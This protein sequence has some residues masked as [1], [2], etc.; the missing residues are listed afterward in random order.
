ML[1]EQYPIAWMH[2]PLV[3]GANGVW[4]QLLDTF[5]YSPPVST[6]STVQY[7]VSLHMCRVLA[8]SLQWHYRRTTSPL[9][10]RLVTV[11]EIHTVL[12]HLYLSHPTSHSPTPG[13]PAAGAGDGSVQALAAQYNHQIR[14]HVCQCLGAFPPTLWVSEPPESSLGYRLP[15]DTVSTSLLFMILLSCCYDTVGTVREASYE[16]LGRCAEGGMGCGCS[17]SH[18]GDLVTAVL[19]KYPAHGELI[20]CKRQLELICI[21]TT[22]P[23]P[24][25]PEGGKRWDGLIPL[26]AVLRQ[27]IRSHW[28]SL[29][30]AVYT[31]L[32]TC[33][34]GVTDTKVLARVHAY[35]TLGTVLQVRTAYITHNIAVCITYMCYCRCTSTL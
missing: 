4:R 32:Y 17:P 16:A 18:L 5:V 22:S 29:L 19:T 35:W 14:S 8:H 31:L 11:R 20:T 34:T 12:I 15:S 10:R 1:A 27:V 33:V 9:W 23:D 25:T 13:T 26:Q 6:S 28:D 21:T 24:A 30:G 3:P 2:S 7:Q